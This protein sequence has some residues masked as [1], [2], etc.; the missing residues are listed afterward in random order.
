MDNHLSNGLGYQI[1]LNLN[2]KKK[3]IGFLLG[4]QV[5]SSTLGMV[6]FNQANS[7]F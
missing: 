6:G 5:T 7:D 2:P 1:L 3:G 4:R